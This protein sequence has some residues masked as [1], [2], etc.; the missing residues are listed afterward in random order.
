MKQSRDSFDDYKNTT[1]GAVVKRAVKSTKTE[2]SCFCPSEYY[3]YDTTFIKL[4][5]TCL[6]YYLI[7]GVHLLDLIQCTI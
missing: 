2:S 6:L 4:L 1:A 5:L 3:Q 7:V